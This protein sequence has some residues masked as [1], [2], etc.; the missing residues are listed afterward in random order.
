M[1]DL[2]FLLYMLIGGLIGTVVVLC[3]VPVVW[4]IITGTPFFH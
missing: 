2:L 4:C 3:T 1:K